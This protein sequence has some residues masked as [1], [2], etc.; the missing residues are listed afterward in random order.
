MVVRLDEPGHE[1]A[2][3]AVDDARVDPGQVAAPL[4]GGD[5]R[6]LDEHVAGVRSRAGA[7]EDHRV[8]EESPVHVVLPSSAPVP[9]PGLLLTSD[10]SAR[11]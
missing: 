6:A 5:A 2:T 11:F 1:G 4:H 7:V 9:Q 3:L 8:G 10:L